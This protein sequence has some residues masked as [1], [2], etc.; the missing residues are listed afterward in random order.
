MSF[1]SDPYTFCPG[2]SSWQG[3]AKEA[4]KTPLLDLDS[5]ITEPSFIAVVRE[6]DLAFAR[7]EAFLV[8]KLTRSDALLPIV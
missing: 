8:L 6:H 4:E 5:D 3:D 2:V 1:A 7:C